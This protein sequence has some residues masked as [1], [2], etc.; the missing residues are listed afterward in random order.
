MCYVR[1]A[2]MVGGLRLDGHEPRCPGRFERDAGWA[3]G[4]ARTL[5]SMKAIDMPE[6]RLPEAV[7]KHFGL[8]DARLTVWNAKHTPLMS[9]MMKGPL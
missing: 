3:N 5:Q 1:S 9:V 6:H 2:V 7:G 4:G 8:D